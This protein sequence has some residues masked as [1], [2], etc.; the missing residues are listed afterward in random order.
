MR[1]LNDISKGGLISQM[2]VVAWRELD[3][4]LILHLRYGLGDKMNA[5]IGDRLGGTIE[6]RLWGEL[7]LALKK[8]IESGNETD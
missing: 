3:S 6:S 1:N 5:Q 2:R 8:D 4:Q 7:I